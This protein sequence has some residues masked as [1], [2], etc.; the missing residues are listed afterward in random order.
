MS[1]L[2]RAVALSA[3]LLL[4]A[5]ATRGPVPAPQPP[6]PAPAPAPAP[7]P[8]PPPPATAR[9]AGVT[10]VAPA[11][12]KSTKAARALEAF[13]QSCPALV[14]RSDQSGLTLA[15]RLATALHQKQRPLRQS[16]QPPS[17]ATG[18]TGPA[19]AMARPLPP[20]ITNP[21][22]RV[23]RPRRPAMR[24]RSIRSPT[25]WSDA[26]DRMGRGEGASIPKGFVS[27]I[28]RGP[29]SKTVL[30]PTAAWRS[31]GRPIRS[32]CSS[33]RSRVRAA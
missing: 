6:A 24:F 26:M 28:I 16:K 8:V 1:A 5:C 9:E 25:I 12:L 18:S 20:A 19:S 23:R 31:A 4:A 32:S 33:F 21:R 7:V 10:L 11:A 2:R 17:S 30:L 3:S 29:R 14:Q 27:F 13:R 15:D 22:S